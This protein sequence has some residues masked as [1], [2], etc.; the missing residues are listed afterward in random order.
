MTS[1]SSLQGVEPAQSSLSG[2]PALVSLPKSSG[3]GHRC[4]ALAPLG[5]TGVGALRPLLP[6][7]EH[8]N[9]LRRP[10]AVGLS[11]GAGV[12]TEVVQL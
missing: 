5:A 9:K 6:A 11:A 7:D 2:P 12:A 3:C 4:I 10:V 8:R 1:I